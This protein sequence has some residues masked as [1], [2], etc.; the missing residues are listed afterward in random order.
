MSH[1]NV[2]QLH[3]PS[4]YEFPCTAAPLSPSATDSDAG[5]QQAFD[6]MKGNYMDLG[7]YNDPEGSATKSRRVSTLA[8]RRS[9][10]QEVRDKYTLK[11]T[12]GKTL[13]VVIPPPDFVQEHT[14][15]GCPSLSGPQKRLHQGVLM[16]LLPTVS[17]SL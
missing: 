13:V 8:Y 17:F 4:P 15:F 6:P 14:Q 10:G 3:T 7:S 9:G 11:N 16:P 2:S 1:F 5:L 12:T